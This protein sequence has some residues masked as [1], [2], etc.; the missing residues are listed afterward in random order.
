MNC[1]RWLHPSSSKTLKKH[2]DLFI[3]FP[4]SWT[5][6]QTLQTRSIM[7]VCLKDTLQGLVTLI[8]ILVV[9]GILLYTA[10]FW[11][12]CGASINHNP[13]THLQAGIRKYTKPHSIKDITKNIYFS[14]V[15]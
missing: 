13:V 3:I 10:A 12:S 5:N 7:V 15:F 1:L 14:L 6:L 8:V 4:D 2:Y 11:R 9:N